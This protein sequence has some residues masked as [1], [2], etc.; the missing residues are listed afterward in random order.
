M[1]GDVHAVRQGQPDR[2]SLV[3]V[4]ATNSQFIIRARP[5]IDMPPMRPFSA[6]LSKNN[7]VA[8]GPR[9]Q[10]SSETAVRKLVFQPSSLHPSFVRASHCESPKTFYPNQPCKGI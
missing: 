3:E 6:G 10:P 7:A 9:R 2:F 5:H 4:K 8:A 1:R